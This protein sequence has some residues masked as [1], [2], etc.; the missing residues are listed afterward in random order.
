MARNLPPKFYEPEPEEHLPQ[1]SIQ[2]EL[3]AV[4]FVTVRCDVCG[5]DPR[6][7]VNPTFKVRAPEGYRAHAMPVPVQCP[8]CGGGWCL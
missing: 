5:L 2:E 3:E 4:G 6:P 7:G 8:R 1:R